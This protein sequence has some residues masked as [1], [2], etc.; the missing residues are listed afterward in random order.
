MD[1]LEIALVVLVLV[2]T[3]VYIG[4]GIGVFVLV[5]EL[6]KGIDKINAILTVTQRTAQNVAEPVNIVANGVRELVHG[7]KPAEPIRTGLAHSEV[8]PVPQV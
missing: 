1:A 8:P 2:W 7:E 5:R 3:L 6:R 4:L